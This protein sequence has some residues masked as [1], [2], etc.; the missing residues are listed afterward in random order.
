MLF[1]GDVQLA[2]VRYT[3]TDGEMNISNVVRSDAGPY[4]C[5]YQDNDNLK[6][7]HFVEVHY[8]P[9]IQSVTPLEQVVMKGSSV[10]LE[11][12]AIG[13]PKPKIR[14]TREGGVLP[15]GAEVEESLSI[16]MASI[17]RHMDGKYTC[18]ADN[19][20]GVPETITMTVEVEYPPETIIEKVSLF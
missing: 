19:G 11:C 13:N 9:T 5:Y 15:S 10:S 2:S 16:T 1:V 12:T 8:P 3:L 6:L 7:R 20:V 4:L 17:T 14:W 18:S